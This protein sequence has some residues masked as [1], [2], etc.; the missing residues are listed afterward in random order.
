[1]S[2]RNRLILAS[3]LVS[4]II[5]ISYGTFRV[6]SKTNLPPP[7]VTVFVHGYKGTAVSFRSM[8]NRFE[9]EQQWGK[10][11]IV[12]HVT[13]DSRVLCDET[14]RIPSSG[15][16]FVQL[17][18][19]NNRASFENTAYW[20]SKALH[21]LHEKYQ[22]EEVN[23]VGHSMGGIVSVKFLEEYT[24]KPGYPFISKLVVLGSPFSGLKDKNYLNRNSGPAAVD[25][26]PGSAA[27][28]KLFKQ[29]ESF[30]SDVQV[31]AIASSGDQIVS[32]DSALRL[33]KIVPASNFHKAVISDSALNHSGLHESKKVDQLISHFLWP[34]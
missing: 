12:C 33:E 1:M 26:M 14:G 21:T 27:L 17:I 7:N 18:F 4:L 5:F 16:L 6:N 25:L 9:N 15:R 3:L 30:P 24:K 11:A 10:K 8:L 19:D 20:L 23:I 29:K 2:K 13:A 32:V 31:M 34:K 22:F 28:Q